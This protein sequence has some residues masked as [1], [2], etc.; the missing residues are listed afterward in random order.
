[1]KTIIIDSILIIASLI[2]FSVAL[3]NALNRP[4]VEVSWST[5]K[6]VRVVYMDGR[7]TDCSVLPEKYDQIWVE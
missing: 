1:M 5:K 6:C 2:F 4:E 7:T 3:Y